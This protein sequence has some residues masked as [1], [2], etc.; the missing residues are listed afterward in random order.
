MRITAVC[1]VFSLSLLVGA[2]LAHGEDKAKTDYLPLKVGNTWTY[3]A[4]F[5]GQKIPF[6]QK[7]TKIEKK[8]GQ[9]VASVEADFGGMMMTEQM[10][11]NDKGILR[12][13]FQG[14][15]VDPPVP[16]LKLPVKKGETWDAKLNIMGQ[17]QKV[18]MKTEGEEEVTVPAGKYKA[19]VVSMVIGDNQATLKQWFAPNVGIV[20]TTFEFGG[21][22]GAFELEK[23]EMA[24]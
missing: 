24:K 9:D 6:T 16:A 22:G 23:F 7:V 12:H 4:E 20:K 19:V 18:T 5:G 1:T 8:N 17:E 3:K 10:S 15:P 21:N 2:P 11:S 13:T 14:M